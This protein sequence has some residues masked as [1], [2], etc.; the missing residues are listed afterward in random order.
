MDDQFV[1]FSV[2][3]YLRSWNILAFRGL[4]T[5]LR[6]IGRAS[7]DVATGRGVL[8]LPH[9]QRTLTAGSLR[10]AVEATEKLPTF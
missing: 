8:S 3:L 4:T 5:S 1:T 9:S 10:L 2:A 6:R 7:A